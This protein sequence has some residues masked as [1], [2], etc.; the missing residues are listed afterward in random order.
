M[1]HKKE[2]QED[3]I[4]V[5]IP[6]KDRR[7]SLERLLKS[8]STQ[9]G[10]ILEVMVIDASETPKSKEL[11]FKY[12]KQFPIPLHYIQSRAGSSTQRNVGIK[13]AKGPIYL[14]LDD[15][16]VLDKD[17][18]REIKNV[19]KEGKEKRIGG[20]QAGINLEFESRHKLDLVYLFEYVFFIQ[21]LSKQHR[22]MRSGFCAGTWAMP[23]DIKVTL[24]EE[25][26]FGGCTAYRSEL[27]HEL[28]IFFSAEM[29][30]FG[31]YAYMEDSHFSG[32]VKK[33]GY[34]LA[35]TRNAKFWHMCESNSD[36][37]DRSFEAM[38][39]FNHYV[40]WRD[41]VQHDV[42]ACLAFIWGN[43]GLLLKNI[44]FSLVKKKGGKLLGFFDGIKATLSDI[45]IER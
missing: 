5:I 43:F 13:L 34:L 15:D 2:I 35:R 33:A 18:I 37:N 1:S 24:N 17:C 27:F 23:E 31:G 44:G 40:I 36:P 16:A 11:I 20:V 19:F 28:K 26:L 8:L 12:T 6:T 7:G 4:S 21:K 22:I 41:C 45:F 38:K 9:H 25:W 30:K 14:F 29:E 10:Y 32:R 3:S 42:F 39:T